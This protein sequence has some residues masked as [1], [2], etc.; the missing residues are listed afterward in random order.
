MYRQDSFFDL[1]G[2]GQVGLALLS[3][4]LFLLM[5]L[6]ARRALRPFPIWVRLFGALSLFWL[7][8]WLS[9]QIYYMYYRL[10]IPDLPLQWVIWPPRDPLKSLEM[11]IFS[12]EQ[13]LSAHGQGIL[14]WAVIL[15]AVLPRRHAGRSGG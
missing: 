12:Y 1:S 7:F 5:V 6:L 13:N 9:P 10:V 14:G 3:A 4:I 8:V 2:W 11:L 15:A